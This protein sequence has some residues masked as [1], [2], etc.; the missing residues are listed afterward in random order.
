MLAL[1]PEPPAAEGVRTARPRQFGVNLAHLGGDRAVRRTPG[2][3]FR[4]MKVAALGN[5]G[6]RIA[7]IGASGWVRTLCR[8]HLDIYSMR[9]N[10]W[11][12]PIRVI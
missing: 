7:T 1:T 11:A 2:E 6:Q 4:A 5:H 8:A 10:V 9:L 12:V 3:A